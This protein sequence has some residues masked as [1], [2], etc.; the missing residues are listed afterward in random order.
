MEDES[1][2][3]S[4]SK[5]SASASYREGYLAGWN[6]AWK[7]YYE[8]LSPGTGVKVT[9]AGSNHSL[10]PIEN[11]G[12]ESDSEAGESKIESPHYQLSAEW[13][14]FFKQS[15]ELRRAVQKRQEALES[16]TEQIDSVALGAIHDAAQRERTEKLYGVRAGEVLR[17]E[18]RLD[19]DYA[20][21]TAARRAPL[22]PVLPLK[23]WK[24]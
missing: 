24:K 3:P 13:A 18:A 20:S 8:S 22:W 7:E 4:I 17:V 1:L 19:A 12:E 23:E 9:E 10:A 2:N 14:A 11:P 16:Q 15:A 21:A 6:K 5:A